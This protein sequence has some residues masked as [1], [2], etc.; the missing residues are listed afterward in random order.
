MIMGYVSH[1][2]ME[3]VRW[4]MFNQL[5]ALNGKRMRGGEK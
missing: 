5:K 4:V 3:R 2:E 1:E